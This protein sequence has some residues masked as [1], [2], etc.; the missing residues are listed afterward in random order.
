[1]KINMDDKK[2]DQLI[3]N[4][5]KLKSTVVNPK[6]SHKYKLK[7]TRTI[8]KDG[9]CFSLVDEYVELYAKIISD[10][11]QQ[12]NWNRKISYKYAEDKFGS[13]L[14][15]LLK[16]GNDEHATEYFEDLIKDF[17]IVSSQECV[18]FLPIFGISMELNSIKLGKIKLVKLTN[19]KISE[20][21]ELTRIQLLKT[22][23]DP[24][25][26]EFFILEEHKRIDKHLS[27]A[28]TCAEFHVFAEINRAVE[29]AEEEAQ[30]VID[31][32]RFAIPT[33]Y[34]R[35]LRVFI[36]LQGEYSHQ[37]RY[38][39]GICVDRFVSSLSIILK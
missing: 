36:G 10:I 13:L 33:L 14:V 39:L 38:V 15:K 4:I 23:N 2:R 12:D 3:I 30:N 27:E 6:E 19:E 22:A 32:F 26:K 8:A 20:I 9:L 25:S 1:M 7:N 29:L 16:D 5:K 37:D 18:I 17:E 24:E 35:N 31:I 11:L 34:A 21:K 28:K